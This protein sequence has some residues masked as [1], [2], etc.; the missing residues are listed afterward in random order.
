MVSNPR[1]RDF[2]SDALTTALG[3]RDPYHF[4]GIFA[5]YIGKI[6]HRARAAR[7]RGFDSLPSLDP[8]IYRDIEEDYECP[9][10]R[11]PLVSEYCSFVKNRKKKKVIYFKIFK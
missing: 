2:E 6:M 5:T 8:D 1:S 7:P 3:W 11:G 9:P 4:F 10:P